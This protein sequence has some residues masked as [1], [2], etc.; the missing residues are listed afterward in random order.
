[1]PK[2]FYD[3]IKLIAD[4]DGN[5]ISSMILVLARLGMQIYNADLKLQTSLEIPKLTLFS[6]L[7]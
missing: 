7:M 5:S 3:E 6:G 2:P 4:R 1:V